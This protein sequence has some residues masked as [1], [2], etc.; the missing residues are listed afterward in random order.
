MPEPSSNPPEPPLD[1]WKAIAAYLNRDVRT[2]RRWEASEGLPVH[3]HK[4]LVRSSVY[5][6]P[7]ELEAWRTARRL[8]RMPAVG[9]IGQTHLRAAAMAALAASA[10]VSG[11]D[12]WMSGA[13][14]PAAQERGP[15]VRR[16]WSSADAQPVWIPTADGRFV[17]T[18]WTTGDIAVR[19]PANG[20]MQHLTRANSK[21]APYSQGFGLYPVPSPDATQVAYTWL[22][23]QSAA[24]ELRATSLTPA[25]ADREPR[26]M[27]QSADVRT[28]RARWRRRWP[29]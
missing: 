3:R 10:L 16:V 18:D 12:G 11:G 28:R 8:D 27:F 5:A 22:N 4:H 17:L 26:V 9:P 29:R 24:Y 25:T 21:S 7:G 13:S 15:V 2:V 1:S 14:Q 19:N 6:Y 23:P 20:E